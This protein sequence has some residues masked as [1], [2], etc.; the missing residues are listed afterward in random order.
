MEPP[1]FWL[2]LFAIRNSN[3]KS[4][5]IKVFISSFS[6]RWRY[7]C[8]VEVDANLAPLLFEFDQ[9]EFKET[10]MIFEIFFFSSSVRKLLQSFRCFDFVR[11]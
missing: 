1:N 7:F 9:L 2:R 4:N 11:R 10:Q 3:K 8:L 6:T 5:P